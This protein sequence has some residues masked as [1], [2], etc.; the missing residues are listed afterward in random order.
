MPQQSERVRGSEVGGQSGSAFSAPQLTLPKGG[1]ALRSIDEK[2]SVNAANGTCELT[3][4][5]P[6]S[7]TR[8]GLDGAIDLHYSSG[9]GN[10][11]F[12]L[13]WNLTLP[14]IQRR[15]DKQLPRYEDAAESDVFIF[16]GAEDLVPAY[17]KDG[18]G[19]WIRDIVLDGNARVERYRP[20]IDA[21]VARIEKI[22]LSGEIGFYWKVTS[23]ENVVTIF[24]RTPGAR[25]TDPK[26][27]ARIFRW[28]PEWRYDDKGNC[29]EFV[30]KDED[31]TDVPVSVEEKNRRS[32]IAPF[33]NKY[34]KRI[35]Y[36][37]AN[38]Y[39]ASAVTPFVPAAPVNTLY[40]YE[41]VLDYGEH[42]DDAPK[43]AET[44]TWRCRLDPFSDYRAGFE[45]RT[46]RL[47]RRILLFHYFVEL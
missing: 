30:Y 18:S 24:G 25:I 33:A 15:T 29:S 9:S 20:R 46:Y 45:V 6:F 21:Q 44:E 8:S 38:P 14:S 31:L 4:T 22:S 39:Y 34:L 5:V 37:N 36:G 2:F 42:Y 27:P 16:A 41:A 19:S 13:G 10:G 17:V 12:G 7:K 11:P 43:S 3:I 32:G 26:Q 47:C 40:F 1:G 28:L 23:R 35:R